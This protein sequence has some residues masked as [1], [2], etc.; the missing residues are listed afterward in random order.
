MSLIEDSNNFHPHPYPLPSRERGKR[1]E[2]RGRWSLKRRGFSPIIS[3]PLEGG[4]EVGWLLK[5]LFHP[6]HPHPY[7]L[8]SRER[9]KGKRGEEGGHSRKSEKMQKARPDPK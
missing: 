9:V 2:R 5:K 8:P 4:D 6:F 7:P 1:E 3:S